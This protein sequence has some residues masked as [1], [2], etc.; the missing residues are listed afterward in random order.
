MT[1]SDSKS[2]LAFYL[3]DLHSKISSASSQD[4]VFRG[5]ENKDWGLESSAYLRHANPP[6]HTDFIQYNCE[7]IA[8]AKNANYQVK[9]NNKLVDIELLAELR[10]YGAAT[11]L[12]DFTRDFLVALWFASRA[13][14][15]KAIQ[16][17]GK[18]VE[19]LTDGKVIIVNKGDSEVFFQLTSEDKQNS[20]EEILKFETREKLV[21]PEI[22]PSDID[23]PTSEISSHKKAKLWYWQPRYAINHRLSAQKGVF[24]FGQAKID[25]AGIEYWEVI[26]PQKDKQAIRRELSNRHG[27][28][29]DSL[30]ND[31]PGF[32]EVNDKNHKIQTKTAS[33]YF[34]DAVQYRQ[35]GEFEQVIQSLNK[36]IELDTNE[37]V[38]HF[39]SGTAKLDL[40]RYEDAL[41]SLTNAIE[42]G[43]NN[44]LYYFFRGR[45]NQELNRYEDALRDFSKA[46]ELKPKD[47]AYYYIRGLVNRE[48]N[49]YEDALRDLS[50]AIELDSSIAGHY[51][52]RGLAYQELNRYEDASRDFSKAIELDSSIAVYYYSRGLAY[53]EL[54]RYEDA[55][56]D[57]SKAIELDPKKAIYHYSRGKIHQTLG[58]Q[59]EVLK[60]FTKAIVL[61]PDKSFYYFFRGQVYRE[62]GKL[63]DAQRDFDK[64]NELDPNTSKPTS[65]S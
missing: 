54:N 17:N 41:E 5:L 34:K 7:L 16:E 12:V 33:D 37:A 10:H 13:C 6:T 53:Q 44:D 32:A 58:N 36:A 65:D 23:L 57:F 21:S 38:Y 3:D 40:N 39:S 20:L 31:L 50:K 62:L 26:I 19:I 4:L 18:E 64:A 63:E 1:N 55:S 27:I 29:E 48:L 30:F 8:K 28:N 14:K 61:D 60:Y 47:P 49:R 46:I 2:I 25:L 22:E 42:L 45:S 51:Y 43:P 59:E 52:S 56:R 35:R 11:A 9:E 15:E 24:I